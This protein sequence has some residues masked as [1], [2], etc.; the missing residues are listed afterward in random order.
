KSS[1]LMGSYAYY[2]AYM[3]DDRLVLET[4]RSAHA[5]GAQCAN[6][7]EAQSPVW[8]GEKITGLRLKDQKSGRVFEACGRHI[9][10]C[11]GPWTDEVGEKMLPQWKK[12]LRPTKGIH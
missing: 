4:L 7:F 9:L 6:Y 11:V 1:G 12:V 8:T 2:D 5:M 10:S 3:D